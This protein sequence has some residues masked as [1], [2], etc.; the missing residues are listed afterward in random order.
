MTD[1]DIQRRNV[2]LVFLLGDKPLNM[3]DKVI[4][5]EDCEA[6]FHVME[7]VISADDYLSYGWISGK[8]GTV[9]NYSNPDYVDSQDTLYIVISPETGYHPLR[10]LHSKAWDMRQ[11]YLESVE[12]E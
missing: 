9:S 5:P 6:H 8:I 2:K 4:I 10:F 1:E 3:G 7:G 11:A 12:V